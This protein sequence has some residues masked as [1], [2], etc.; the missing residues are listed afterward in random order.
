M[1]T[2][3]RTLPIES[4]YSFFLWGARQ[5][6]KSTLLRGC[7]PTAFWVDLLRSEQFRLYATRPEVLRQEVEAHAATQVVIDEIQKVPGLL[8]EVHWLME[9]RGVRFALCGSSARKVRRGHANLLGGRAIRHELLG[10]S[11]AEIGPEWDLVRMLNNGY[12]P[13]FYGS[14]RPRQ[15]LNA[16][17]SDYLKEEIV[18]EG[19]VRNLPAF[20]DFLEVAALSDAELVNAN[21]IAREC[22]VS[23]HTVRAYFGIL[24]DSLLARWLPSY[25]RRPKRRVIQAPKFYF[26]DVGLVNLLAKRGQLEPGSQLFGK[27]FEN[28]VFHELSAYVEYT[29][30]LKD[31]SYWRLASGIEVDFV[32][33]QM[34]VAIEAK[35]STRVLSQHLKGLRHLLQDHP[36]VQRRVVVS[37]VPRRRRTEDAIEILS[38]RDF[39]ELLWSGELF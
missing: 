38:A 37:L 8:D 5:T 28:W 9:N 24:E 16:Y 33:D 39:V 29:D 32:V 30:S 2:R 13:S 15:R 36:E 11:A 25:R 23:A 19:L 12:L 3:R 6:G 20:S 27:A 4:E 18:A 10:L 14:S 17:I 21:N 34:R 31:L 7:Y 26:N 1:F 35:A 22:G